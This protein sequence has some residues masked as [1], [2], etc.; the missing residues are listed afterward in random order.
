MIRNLSACWNT[1]ITANTKQGHET[2]G[3]IRFTKGLP[4]GD[5]LC[6]RLFTLC[7]NPVAWLLSAS[8]GYRLSKPLE[9]K[10]T[11]LL[12]VDNLKVFAASEAKLNTV[13]RATSTAMQDIGLQWNPKKC[14]VIHVRRGKQ[15]EDAADLKLD[16][17]TMVKNLEA[18]SS[19]KFLGVKEF[20][21][22][23]ERLALAVAAKVYLH[24]LSVFWTSPLS[25]ANGVKATNQFALPV[26][27]Y[28]MRTQHWPLAELREID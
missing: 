24:R 26:L 25:D 16:E 11:H 15:V 9:T 4:Q 1:R 17:A 3:P 20:T 7:L 14:N 19:Y 28:P 10:V 22:K 23:D 12:Y 8:Q 5:A 21:L 27:T 6:P 2:S 13:L 18:G